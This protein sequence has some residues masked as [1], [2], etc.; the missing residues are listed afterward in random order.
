MSRPAYHDQVREIAAICKELGITATELAARVSVQPDTMR[1]VANG[2]QKASDQLMAA[3]RM[4]RDL[5]H[6]HV[7]SDTPVRKSTSDRETSG[8]LDGPR[9]GMLLTEEERKGLLYM[10]RDKTDEEIIQQIEETLKDQTIDKSIRL[11]SVR[12]WLEVLEKRD[13]K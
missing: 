2:Y 8:T 3:I 1:K 11:S 10:V 9:I 6:Y 5:A 4:V 13:S 7:R 12:L